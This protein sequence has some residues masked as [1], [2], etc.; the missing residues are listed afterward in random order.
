LWRPVGDQY[1]ADPGSVC[2][3]RF[4]VANAERIITVLEQKGVKL[5]EEGGQGIG[6]RLANVPERDIPS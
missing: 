4:S 1:L 3:R 5:I 6:V 2:C